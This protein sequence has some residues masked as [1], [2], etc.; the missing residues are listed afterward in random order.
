ME[1]HMPDQLD[2]EPEASPLLGCLAL[3]GVMTIAAL[4]LVG[5]YHII[6]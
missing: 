2:R 1:D 3:V 6:F 4:A 5:S